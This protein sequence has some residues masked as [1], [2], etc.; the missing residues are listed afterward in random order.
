M[1]L[2]LTQM[3]LEDC[4]GREIPLCQKQLHLV[5]KLY[6]LNEIFPIV[7]PVYWILLLLE[8]VRLCAW[9]NYKEMRELAD[10]T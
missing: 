4:Q 8:S 3:D 1:Y 5:V 10:P 2:P 6:L 7:F 9:N